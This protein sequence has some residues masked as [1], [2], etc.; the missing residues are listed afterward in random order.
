MGVVAW[1]KCG[2]KSGPI[3]RATSAPRAANPARPPTPPERVF[4]EHSAG[5]QS[6]F[7]RQPAPH[8]FWGARQDRKWHPH[9][10]HSI[11]SSSMSSPRQ[12]QCMWGPR[13]SPMTPD[14]SHSSEPPTIHRSRGRAPT[15]RTGGLRHSTSSNPPRPQSTTTT[16]TTT[17]TAMP[18]PMSLPMS[19]SSMFHRWSR[20]TWTVSRPA[21]PDP[22]PALPPAND[23]HLRHEQFCTINGH[24]AAIR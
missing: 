8:R 6:S 5:G 17:T 23:H 11:M 21:P 22:H 16:S 12:S 1:A 7:G 18:A 2:H 24:R 14:E 4:Q 3:K 20:R 10:S 19:M 9:C 13:R 15:S